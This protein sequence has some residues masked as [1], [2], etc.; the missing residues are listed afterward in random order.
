MH[1]GTWHR[2]FRSIAIAIGISPLFSMGLLA[3]ITPDQTLGAESSTVNQGVTINGGRGDRIEGGA[4]RGGNLFHSFQD[5]NIGEGQRIYFSSPT[6]INHI[7]SRVT[8]QNASNLLGTLGVQGEGNLFFLNPNGIIFGQN[9]RLDLKGSFFASTAN[10]IQFGSQ[11][12]FSTTD[13][14]APPLLTIS[15]SAFVFSH[16]G[17]IISSATTSIQPGLQGLVVADGKGLT[18]LGG[19]VQIDGGNG[20]GGL[21]A[22]SGRIEI[23]AVA[24]T[25][26][27]DWNPNGSL[28]FPADMARGDVTLTNQARVRVSRDGQGDIGI[29]ARNIN[30]REGSLIFAGIASDLGAIGQQAGN[31]TLNAT[32]DITMTG[33][34]VVANTMQGR[35]NAGNID[36]TGRSLS[37]LDNSQ[38]LGL[39]FSQGNAGSISLNISDRI[40]LGKDTFLGTGVETKEAIGSSGNL[41]ITTNSL[42]L[43]DNAA[44]FADTFG[45]GNAGDII[46]NARDVVSLD[47][48]VILANVASTATGNG[49]K[50]QITAKSL[51]LTTGSQLTSSTRGKGDAGGVKIAVEQ[52]VVLD[53]TTRDGESPSEIFSSVNSKNAV[54][55][56][57]NIEITAGSLTL[58]NGARLRASTQGR[59]NAGNILIT[60]RD[61]LLFD[62]KSR[63]GRFTTA[64][65][66]GVGGT[67]IG[68]GGDIRISGNSLVVSNEAELNATANGKGLAG[69]IMIDSRSVILNRGF[70]TAEAEQIGGANISLQNLDL[71]LLKNGSSI[72]A[73][74]VNNAIGG[75]ITINANNGVIVAFP[76]QD[77]DIIA[78]A[79]KGRGGNITITAQSILGIEQRRSLPNNQTNDID[80]S[81]QFNQS[82]TITI[83]RLGIDP[84]QG[85]AELPS[86]PRSPQTL[87]G[88][89]SGGAKG[90]R[91]IATGT[92]GL[93]SHPSDPLSGLNSL[94]DLPLPA[95][96]QNDRTLSPLMSKTPTVEEAQ[97][98]RINSQGQV[99][100]VALETV[101]LPCGSPRSTY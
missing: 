92:G 38:I 75:N 97:T 1:P 79:E 67:G 14:T 31:I 10:V 29:T 73:Q 39:T 36:I 70:L 95:Q 30:L 54:G 51:S 41:R 86:E 16:P 61:S 25:G 11:G 48:S 74:A 72:S 99:Q 18:L 6:G 56:S 82:G 23:G 88:C 52:A 93:P 100:L 68:N 21:Y 66:T 26:K 83:N 20:A 17:N 85:L 40:S 44:V 42:Y 49:G 59:G 24:G 62:G 69:N 65:I 84:V 96:W 50:I 98:W 9:A 46:I 64:A 94:D 89:Q 4:I 5:F 8:G 80:A 58:T 35:G 55:N 81:S 32:G 7:F 78:N 90:G 3:Q 91:L 101:K 43:T 57:N 71:L 76:N 22:L 47:D 77:S 2:W 28:G 19:N 37:L 87:A 53:G 27:I 33:T 12:F 15:P 63:N 13:G 34:S 60:V 45:K